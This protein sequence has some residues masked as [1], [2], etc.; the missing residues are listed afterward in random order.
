MD[1]KQIVTIIKK[2]LASENEGFEDIGGLWE[3]EEGI[4]EEKVEEEIAMSEG[5]SEEDP[6]SDHIK[7]CFWDVISG[8]LIE[9]LSVPIGNKKLLIANPRRKEVMALDGNEVK[10]YS[11]ETDSWSKFSITNWD[12]ATNCELNAEDCN[13]LL[14]RDFQKRVRL[15][16]AV[17]GKPILKLKQRATTCKFSQDGKQIISRTS[18]GLIDVVDTARGYN[19][20][21]L[22]PSQLGNS[23]FQSNGQIF[24]TISRDKLI[25]Q[26]MSATQTTLKI[27]LKNEPKDRSYSISIDL[28]AKQ[29]A[30]FSE[31]TGVVY[32]ER[33]PT[34]TISSAP[35]T[36]IRGSNNK[37]L[38]LHGVIVSS[39][40]KLS[41]KNIVILQ[42]RGDYGAFQETILNKLFPSNPEEFNDVREVIAINK[43]LTPIH[44]RIIGSNTCWNNLQKLDLSM[45]AIGEEGGEVIGSNKSWPNLE[46]LTLLDAQIGNSTAIKVANNQTWKKLKKLELASN[47]I[48]DIGAIEIG[49]SK[50]WVNLEVL[51]LRNNQI[52]DK[53]ASAIGGNNTWEKLIRLDLSSNK[54]ND[55]QTIIFVCSNGTWKNLKHLLLGGNPVVFEGADTIKAIE[56]IASMSLEGLT[57]PNTEFGHGLLHYLKNSAPESVKE[58]SLI[59]RGYNAIHTVAIG[60]NTTWINL[61]TLHLEKNRIR[62]EGA[63]GLSRN[64][65]WTNLQSLHLKD[66]SIR[67]KGAADLATNTYWTNL[68]TL[69]LGGN[70][71]GDEGAI[72]LS[73]N[74]SWTN[75][76]TL[77]LNSNRIGH[78]G[79]I[80]LGQNTSWT[81]LQSLDLLANEIRDKGAAGLSQNTTWTNLQTLNL[82]HNKIG[83]K[84]AT[85]LGKNTSWTN[86]QTLNLVANKICDEGAIGLSQNTSW[87][88]LATLNLGYNLIGGKG[89]AGLGQNATWISLQTLELGRN[90]ID[91]K[92]ATDLRKNTTWTK[93]QSLDLMSN[94]IGDEGAIG[95]SL[96]K[97][98]TNLQTLNLE[99]NKIGV[100]GALGLSKNATWTNLQALTLKY[101]QI[102]DEGAAALSKNTTWI[103]LQRLNLSFN[104]I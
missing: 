91:A 68:Q 11:I 94:K 14:M 69:N 25:L 41:E 81:N 62:D 98:W 5:K 104:S 7:I 22:S 45:N 40:D 55:N 88:N 9:E 78:E 50:L 8:H 36:A 46:V 53:G 26:D 1:G 72:G 101:N 56:G 12:E 44:A 4:E 85:D 15:Y 95:L 37:G 23:S 51:D 43:N 71:I 47:H 24:F 38:N 75:L 17:T 57:L 16:S 67:A 97:T 70:S 86:L 6:Q 93:L 102:G 96:N 29:V 80:A 33:L 89:A 66:N 79:A 52:E 73:K 60:G 65:S 54:I 49:K 82:G 84:G 13:T 20:K 99:S 21:P 42:K 35:M 92:G 27:P 30:Y 100:E 76:Q 90:S 32:F 34:T 74:T 3:N 58:I 31:N 61:Q 19:I 64:T 28:S 10:K 63:T 39:C 18:R 48:S 59:E 77:N 83:N 103:N 2:R 87:T